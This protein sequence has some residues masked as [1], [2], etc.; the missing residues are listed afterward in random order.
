MANASGRMLLVNKTFCADVAIPES[1]FLAASDYSEVLGLEASANCMASDEEAWSQDL[2]CYA[3]EVLLLADGE[4]HQLEII[5]TQVKDDGGNAIGLIGLGV[6]VTQQREAQRQLQK[7]EAKFRKLAEQETLLN[8]LAS[9]IRESLDLDTILATTVQQIRALL[10]LDHCVFIWYTPESSPPVWAVKYESK[11]AD[12]PS[13]L[14][15]FPADATGSHAERIANLEIIRIDD[16]ETV[17]DPVEREFFMSVGLK[18]L[19]S[20]PIQ[21][22]GGKIGVISCTASSGVRCWSD[23]EVEL[24]VAVGNQLAIAINQ[25]E[26]YTQSVNS[27]RIAQEQTKQ[28][29]LALCELQQAQTQLIQAEKMS[30]LGQMVAGI[31]HEINN[32]VS[33]IFGNLTYTE[34]YIGSLMKLLQMYRDEYPEPAAAIQD[35]IDTLELD[36]LLHDLL[37]MLS[38][39]QVGATRI[40]DIVRSLRNFSRLDESDMKKVNIDEGIDSTLMILEHRLK[41]QPVSVAGK[42]YHRPA[43]Q[44]VKEYGELPLV[45]CYA[46]LLNQVFMNIIANAIDVLQEPLPNPGMIRIRTEIEGDCVTIGISDNGTGM[47]DQVKQRIFDPFYTTKAIGSGTGMGLAISHSII[48][49]K[50]Q[51]EIKCLSVVGKGTEFMIRIPIVSH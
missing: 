25:A 34:E 38:S 19:L 4:Y 10:Q 28:L 1:S 39:M 42:E 37:K 23:E 32:P 40:R 48:V 16:F 33:F 11:N 2:P 46:G 36:F 35:E 7:S 13:L 24:L 8:Q 31:A 26:L 50:H 14:G 49:E 41:V 15:L 45:E 43:I 30:S 47:T 51:G 17:T 27:V 9:N 20:I 5:K 29:E 44:V 6:D 22:S 3:E 18:S 21:I 12:L